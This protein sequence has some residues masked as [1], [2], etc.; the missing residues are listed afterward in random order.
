MKLKKNFFTAQECYTGSLLEYG[1]LEETFY[2]DAT[3]VISD[4]IE[5]NDLVVRNL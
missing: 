3:K 2:V 1:K 4:W 5:Q